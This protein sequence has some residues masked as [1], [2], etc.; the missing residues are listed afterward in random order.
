MRNVKLMDQNRSNSEADYVW[1]HFAME[2]FDDKGGTQEL[3][4]VGAFNNWQLSP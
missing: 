2:E 3:Y 1:V 4:I